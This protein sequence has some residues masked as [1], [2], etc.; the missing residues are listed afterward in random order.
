MDIIDEIVKVEKDS[1]NAPLT[2]IPLDV[3]VV[4]MTADELMQIG[5]NV[6]NEDSAS[7]SVRDYQ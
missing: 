6:E 5:W 3:S 2:T 4:E 7:G 1:L